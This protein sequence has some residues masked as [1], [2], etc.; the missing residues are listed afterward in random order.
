MQ[1][2]TLQCNRCQ[3]YFEVDAAAYRAAIAECERRG[4]PAVIHCCQLCMEL[5]MAAN[6]DNPELRQVARRVKILEIA[7]QIL[8]RLSDSFHRDAD[9]AAALRLCARIAELEPGAI[10]DIPRMRQEV[11]FILAEMERE[12]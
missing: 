12:S 1:N 2:V 6:S 10:D 3:K 11:D 4:I 8:P 5:E 9:T 7:L